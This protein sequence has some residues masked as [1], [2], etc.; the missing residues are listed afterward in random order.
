MNPVMTVAQQVALLAGFVVALLGFPAFAFAGGGVIFF[1]VIELDGLGRGLV[2]VAPAVQSAV[3]F[4]E[5]PLEHRFWPGWREPGSSLWRELIFEHAQY[6]QA[7]LMGFALGGR[8]GQF[9]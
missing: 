3:E 2:E 1:L 9:V 6:R 5:R 4:F 7:T 8:L